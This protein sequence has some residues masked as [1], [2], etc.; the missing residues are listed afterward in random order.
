MRLVRCIPTDVRLLACLLVA[1][2]LP[3][4]HAAAHGEDIPI[5]PP[6]FDLSPRLVGRELVAPDIEHDWRTGPNAYVGLPLARSQDVVWGGIDDSGVPF[7]GHAR[8]A[9]RRYE[10]VDLISVVAATP[11]YVV[12][13]AAGIHI[14]RNGASRAHHIESNTAERFASLISPGGKILILG[15]YRQ[16]EALL[17]DPEGDAERVRISGAPNLSLPA[18]VGEQ[19]ALAQHRAGRV[20]ISTQSGSSIVR[21]VGR[22]TAVCTRDARPDVRALLRRSAGGYYP[23]IDFVVDWYGEEACIRRITFDGEDHGSVVRSVRFG[24]APTMETSARRGMVEQR[25]WTSRPAAPYAH[26]RMW[27]PAHRA[28]S[29]VSGSDGSLVVAGRRLRPNARFQVVAD[30]YRV[31]AGAEVTPISPPTGRGCEDHACTVRPDQLLP[32]FVRWEGTV[33]PSSGPMDVPVFVETR[34]VLSTE[35]VRGEIA[36]L[37]GDH[38]RSLFEHPRGRVHGTGFARASTDP[39]A[40]VGARTGGYLLVGDEA[41]YEDGDFSSLRSARRVAVVHDARGQVH[42]MAWPRNAG[43][44]EHVIAASGDAEMGFVLAQ[45]NWLEPLVSRD[46]GP[47]SALPPV[48]GTGCEPVPI[49]FAVEPTRLVYVDC[50]EETA[51]LFVR[52]VRLEEGVFRDYAEPLRL[53]APG[54]SVG[55]GAVIGDATFIAVTGERFLTIYRTQNRSFERY[56]D[57]ERKE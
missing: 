40:I 30:L 4:Q 15:G 56:V 25:P 7:T 14:I 39:L 5:E 11:T 28:D 31:G 24:A 46:G 34:Y 52:A 42:R 37:Y 35:I 51:D 38:R 2:T 1:L 6:A 22:E 26:Q 45:E 44:H 29:I 10:R 27:R 21:V 57:I 48:T 49:A 41:R 18:F 55:V 3:A 9:M 33:F 54:T 50:S 13:D 32:G 19:W 47:L 8:V 20:Q 53:D 12:L 43:I 36:W 23:M 17:V 16:A